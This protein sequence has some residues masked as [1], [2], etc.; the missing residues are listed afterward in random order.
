MD[1]KPLN[2]ILY[3]LVIAQFIIVVPLSVFAGD[4][5]N[6]EITDDENDMFEHPYFNIPNKSLQAIDIVS[7]WFYE[8]QNESNYLFMTIK[9]V[10][11]NYL[12][13]LKSTYLVV[14]RHDVYVYTASLTIQF[15]GLYSVAVIKRSY[16]TK[17]N[18]IRAFFDKENNLVTF[19][20]PKNLIDNPQHGDVLTG[21]R[22]A[23]AITTTFGFILDFYL[24]AD[25]AP[26]FQAS[27]ENYIIQY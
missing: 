25:T 4:E 19:K 23:S 5:Q 21:T 12:F 10:N 26:N 13:F 17:I 24:A 1:K 16:P 6:P 2:R 15:L 7:A 20:I 22:A 14:W 11:L 27:G 8:D 3:L 9:V 18:L